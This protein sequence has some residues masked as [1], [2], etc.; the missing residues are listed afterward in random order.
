MISLFPVSG[1]PTK[2]LG[3]KALDFLDQQAQ[4]KYPFFLHLSGVAPHDP[5]TP[6][7]KY[8]NLFPNVTAPRKPS[9]NQSDI[10]IFQYHI[11]CMLTSLDVSNSPSFIKMLPPFNSS[12]TNV[13]DE[14]C[15]HFPS[16]SPLSFF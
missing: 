12:A 15:F 5:A 16:I 2:I 3:Q 8:A 6:A 10:F 13:T 14:V 1:E 7:M 4:S 9:Y 11:N